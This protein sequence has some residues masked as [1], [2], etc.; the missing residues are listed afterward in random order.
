MEHSQHS[1]QT[2]ASGLGVEAATH[3]NPDDRCLS[4]SRDQVDAGLA[5]PS[6]AAMFSPGWLVMG[7]HRVAH[8]LYGR[9]IPLLPRLLSHLGR[10]LTGTEIH[11]GAQIGVGVVIRHGYGVVI[12]ETAIVG[13]GSVIHQEV[14][15]GGTGKDQGKRHPTLGR[16]VVVGPGAKVLGNIHIGDYARIGAGAIT[17]R[18]AS[19]HATVVGIPGRQ[20]SIAAR[21]SLESLADWQPDLEA[22]VIQQLFSRLQHLETQVQQLRTSNP[23]TVLAFPDPDRV[24]SDQVIEA[25]LDGA[26]I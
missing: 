23:P 14:T 13:D 22:Q 16:G 24:G 5:R 8:R 20:V 15:L 7:I 21:Q 18:S 19:A 17:L 6:R 2:R 26:G 10:F 25:F 1:F 12:G 9:Q 3:A 11:P 4:R